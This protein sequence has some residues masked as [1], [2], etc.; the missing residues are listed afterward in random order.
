M[1]LKEKMIVGTKYWYGIAINNRNF[2]AV[3]QAGWITNST[4]NGETWATPKQIGT[5]D[6]KGVAYG[7][8]RFVAVGLKNW[9]MTSTDGV[10]WTIPKQPIS[11][12]P[13]LNAIIFDG[14]KFIAIGK[15]ETIISSTDGIN[16]T[17]LMS[18]SGQAKTNWDA[19]AYGNG[20]FVTL[21][22]SGYVGVS[23]NDGSTWSTAQPFGYEMWWGITYGDGKFVAGIGSGSTAGK[24]TTSSD[25]I[26]WTEPIRIGT[27][28]WNHVA[29]GN[30]L[31]VANNYWSDFITSTDGFTWTEPIKMKDESG[32][33][34]NVIITA[35]VPMP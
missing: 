25:G 23:T 4:D 14:T 31:F 9:T 6:W 7:N 30:G 1:F 35:I 13:D 28:Q 17:L 27:A 18:A 20:R 15:R 19:I 33:D 2:V 32:K 3:G 24:L 21:G 8:G 5:T 11:D 22:T 26:T 12:T 10:N 16:W 29:Y 34:V